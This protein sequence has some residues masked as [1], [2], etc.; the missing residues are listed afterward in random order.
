[1][2]FTAIYSTETIKGVKYSYHANSIEEA[3]QFAKVKFSSFPNIA[4]IE[5]DC[6]EKA[7]S[8]T[9]VFLNGTTIL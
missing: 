5:N 8:G 2:E 3:I 6:S 7:N 4:I 9:L 1:M